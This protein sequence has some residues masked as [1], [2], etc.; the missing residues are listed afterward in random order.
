MAPNP[1]RRLSAVL[2]TDIVG[3]TEIAAGARGRRLAIALMRH[4]ALA[5]RLLRQHRGDLHDTA[6]DGI[7]ATFA[8]PADPLAY[9]TRATA[10]GARS[11]RR[12]PGRRALR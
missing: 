8:V 7:F 5:R 4:H 12:D 6:G 2:F 1:P 10:G 9:A 3:S 11:R